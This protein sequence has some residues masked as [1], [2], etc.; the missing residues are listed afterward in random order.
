MCG[1]SG[2]FAFTE[3]G[4]SSL[5]SLRASTDAIVSR[6]P[7]S[8]GHF[9]FEGCGLGFRRLAILDLT[10]DGNQPMTDESGRYTIVFNG[11]IF[12]FKELRQKLV[13]RGH[14]FHSQTDTEVVL[15]LYIAE[16]RNFLKKLNGFFD[17][18][19]YDK[20]E[21]SLFLAR[22]RMGEKPLLIYR[23]EDKLLFASEMK[24]LLALGIPRKL[25]YVSLNHYLQLNYIPGPATI[26]KGVKKLL[27]GHYM[28]VK[29]KKVVRKRWYKIPYDPKKAERNKLSYEQ[30]QA[31]LVDLLDDATA[32]R[33][34]ADVPLGAFLSG[35]IDSSVI[36]AL[37]SRH[38]QHL[39]T[40]S[41][42]YRDEPFFDET[43][44]AKLVADR[45]K[46]NHTVFSLTNQD[47]Y[48]HIFDV[49]NY[50]DEPFADSSALAVYILS[51]RT[52]EKVTVALSGDGAD[53]LFAGYNKHMGEFQVRQGG[54][55]AEAVTGLN[56]LWDVLPKSR[57]SFFGNKIRQ[58]Q[59]FSRGMLSGPKDRYWDWAS[60]ASAKD[61]RSLLSAA[62][63]RKIG[64][65]L[66]E[67]RRRDLLEGLHADGDLNEVL[68][69]D[70]TMVLPYDMLAKVDLMSMA[71]SLEVRPPFLDPNV[72][73]FAFSLPVSSKIDANMKKKI[74][75]D[76]FRPMLPEELYKRPKH[77]FEVPLLKWFRGELRPLI[78]DD[79][80]SDAFVEAQGVFDVEAI[81]ALKTQLFSRSPGDV[82][83]RI[84]A[85]IVFQWW[86]KKWMM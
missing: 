78:E 31:K 30:Q 29:G 65:K 46:T 68:L 70:T 43:K 54:F 76:A 5:A 16:G 18:A 61:A 71:N 22:D 41:I 48:D 59:R 39:N 47:L 79:L 28:Y 81:R 50:I 86:W 66:A 85:L 35:G 80:L 34:V 60:F 20:E 82:H 42:G 27:P 77:G 73:R 14:R 8:Q 23:D 11:E 74:V 72:V 15:N 26:F 4:R 2:V 33:L 64:K 25:D 55:K 44:Y 52:R 7:D 1:I 10:A 37:A 36:V 49:L 3:A 19:I 24:S 75:Q 13:Q 6:G 21:D 12:N 40:F 32:R 67:K 69:T 62:S 53:E 45:Y 51:K 9:A 56:L 84:W 83:A 57:N 58:F 38:T 17:F 63:R